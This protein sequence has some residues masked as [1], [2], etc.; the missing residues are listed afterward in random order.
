MFLKQINLLYFLLILLAFPCFIQCK[1][2]GCTDPNAVNFDS[3]AKQDDGTCYSISLPS[4][5]NYTISYDSTNGLVDVQATAS[6]E[7]FFTI[8]FFDVQDSLAIR[9]E[10]GNAS[11]TYSD[12]GVFQI[13]IRAHTSDYDYVERIDSVHVTFEIPVFNTGYTTPISYSNYNLVWNDEFNGSSLNSNWIQEIGNGSWGWGNN[14]S[15]YYRSENTSVNDGFLTITAKEENFGGFNYTSSRIKTQGNLNYKYG[16]IDIRAKLPY[17]QGLWP[18]LWMLGE[19]IS[20]VSWPACGEIDIMEMIGGSGYND[21]TIHGT[22]HWDDNGHASYGGSSSLS[23]GV[24]NDEFH[25]FSIIWNSSSIKWLRDDIEY[26]VLNINN[27]S[28]FHSNF[29]FIFNVAVGGN[30]PGYPNSST[31]FPQT[32]VVDYIRVF[33]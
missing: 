11:Y 30:W 31:V 19:N 12:S 33:Q 21:K 10:N 27:L 16:R 9:T 2:K 28:A 4:N 23:S 24:F 1:K 5:L 29:F 13:K 18:A 15:Q 26:N 8:I 17:S 32:M 25:V 20:S 6:N 14:E 22:A 7:N 3:T